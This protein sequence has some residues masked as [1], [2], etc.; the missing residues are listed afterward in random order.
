MKLAIIII[1][2]G[3]INLFYNLGNYLKSKGIEII[4][5]L[6]NKYEIYK[7]GYQ[8]L[9]KKESVYFLIDFRKKHKNSI[10]KQKREWLPLFST[11]DRVT[12]YGY[13]TSPGDLEE[14]LISDYDMWDYLFK[15]EKIDGV[16]NE[17]VSD[18]IS[19]VAYLKCLQYKKKYL[20]L[21][22]SYFSEKLRI[23]SD[24]YGV[25]EVFQTFSTY[26]KKGKKIFDKDLNDLYQK[27]ISPTVFPDYMKNNPS[28]V[29][30]S[31]M[32]HYLKKLHLI[33]NYIYYYLKEHKNIKKSFETK[34]PFWKAWRLFLREAKRKARIKIMIAKRYFTEPDY[35]EKFL[36]YPL[37]FHPEASTLINAW[38]YIDELPMIKNIAFSL[39]DGYKLYVKTHP[40][41]FGYEGIQ[42]YKKVKAIPRIKLIHYFINSK[43]LIAK[44]CGVITLTSTMGFEALMLKKP[45]FIFGN[46]FYQVHPYCNKIENIYLLPKILS[47]GLSKEYNQQLFE[48]YNLSFLKVYYDCT[49]S[50]KFELFKRQDP[51]NIKRIG[52]E[53]IKS[54]S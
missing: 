13:K 5:V 52:D 16:F 36:I 51:K 2:P 3:Y 25:N 6:E 24:L 48:K 7:E 23:I 47:E 31:L 29:G 50:G 54:I 8:E 34:G 9:F 42:F 37:H 44:S 46:I 43:E 35:N 20:G 32:N 27:I 33:K 49:F 45:V 12:T 18:T 10:T 39:P 22:G 21:D 17:N 4:Y 1:G 41:G 26:L 30:Y 11:F 53:I 14:M 38:P 28:F 19:Y 40:N 15:E